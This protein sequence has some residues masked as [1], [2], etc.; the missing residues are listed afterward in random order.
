MPRLLPALAALAC[1]GDGA[2]DLT[3]SS[4]LDANTAIGQ[5]LPTEATRLCDETRGWAERAY[6]VSRL[7]EPLCRRRAVTSAVLAPTTTDV[8]LE[9][10]CQRAYDV[11]L[12]QS[13]PPDA[14][15]LPACVAPGKS[16]PATVGQLTACMNDVYGVFVAALAEVAPCGDLTTTA[17]A[18][19]PRRTLT[20]PASCQA[21]SKSC[22]QLELPW[23][24]EVSWAP[25]AA[26]P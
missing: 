24:P 1:G 17:A 11:C 25:A 13:S 20:T 8:A 6:A 7:H 10:G 4:A 19:V 18:A 3:F 12:Q 22:P 2:E 23:P 5:L 9:A 16:C 15:A 21:L 26:M 14:P